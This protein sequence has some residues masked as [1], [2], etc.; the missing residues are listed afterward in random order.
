MYCLVCSLQL[1][2]AW[3][4]RPGGCRACIFMLCCLAPLVY[5]NI[6]FNNNQVNGIPTQCLNSS[7]T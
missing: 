1:W 6:F 2:S 3:P 7:D 5:N 4:I